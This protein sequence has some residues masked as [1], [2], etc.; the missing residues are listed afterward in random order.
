M[1]QAYQDQG[2][3]LE[4]QLDFNVSKGPRESSILCRAYSEQS[5]VLHWNSKKGGRAARIHHGQDAS[6][7]AGSRG[8]REKGCGA[9][10]CLEADREMRVREIA[11]DHL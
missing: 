9:F 4:S 8:G 11:G 2:G 6:E 7:R 5:K 10:Y 1:D 3:I